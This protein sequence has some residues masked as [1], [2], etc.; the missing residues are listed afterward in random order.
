MFIYIKE[1]TI[2]KTTVTSRSQKSWH[3][4]S[5]GT[6]IDSI[7]NNKNSARDL[8]SSFQF[9]SLR[10]VLITLPN[11]NL[12]GTHNVTLNQNIMLFQPILT[13][14]NLHELMF[15]KN[16]LRRVNSRSKD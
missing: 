3:Q 7:I 5:V 4:S 9:S 12:K 14:K 2:N 11:R 1:L 13:E 16:T 15:S 6:W 10:E 8:K